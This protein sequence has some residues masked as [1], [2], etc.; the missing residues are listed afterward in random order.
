MRYPTLR[1]CCFAL[2]LL[3]F[4]GIASCGSSACCA[5]GWARQEDRFFATAFL[6]SGLLFLAMILASLAVVGGLMMASEAI[7]GKLM[8]SVST[9]LPALWPTSWSMSMR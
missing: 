2:N 8:D 3:P 1:V 6:G 4:A 7:P 9:G 5:T